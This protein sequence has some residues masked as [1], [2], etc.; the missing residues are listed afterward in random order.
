MRPEAVE[1]AGNSLIVNTDE[2][3]DVGAGHADAQ[4]KEGG[5]HEQQR[6]LRRKELRVAAD[7]EDMLASLAAQMTNIPM[8]ALPTVGD[9]GM[10]RGIGAGEI[11]AV[12][13]ETSEPWVLLRFVHP[14][15]DLREA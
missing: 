4:Q 12:G 9:K 14:R 10:N 11:D 5:L 13:M 15:K 6:F 2:T 1:P 3:G 8:F 7:C